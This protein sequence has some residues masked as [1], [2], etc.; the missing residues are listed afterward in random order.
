MPHD[1]VQVFRDRHIPRT[2]GAE[3]SVLNDPC[4]FTL[5]AIRRRVKVPH[6]PIEELSGLMRAHR[7]EK[8][9]AHVPL[10]LVSYACEFVFGNRLVHFHH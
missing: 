1:I 8:V 9:V 4:A 2:M 5:G 10:S 3:M 7:C 6:P